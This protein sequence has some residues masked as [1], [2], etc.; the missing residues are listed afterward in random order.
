VR[1][2]A[3]RSGEAQRAGQQPETRARTRSRPVYVHSRYLPSGTLFLGSVDVKRT[4]HVSELLDIA[5]ESYGMIGA[6]TDLFPDS[7]APLEMQD[8]LA[9]IKIDGP[10]SLQ[11]AVRALVTE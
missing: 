8:I 5:E 6:D 1:T 4:K 9:A 7:T 2:D 11:S 10:L 3:T